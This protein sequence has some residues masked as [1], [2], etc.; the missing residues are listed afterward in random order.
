MS[1]TSKN[2]WLSIA[3][4]VLLALGIIGASIGIS[5]L[6]YGDPLCAIKKCVVIKGGQNE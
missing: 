2:L 4:Y 6:V 1:K 5:A 3:G